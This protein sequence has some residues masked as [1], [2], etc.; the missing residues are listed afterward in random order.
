MK[1]DFKVCTTILSRLPH[2]RCPTNVIRSSYGLPEKLNITS[3]TLICQS[4]RPGKSLY[5]HTQFEAPPLRWLNTAAFWFVSTCKSKFTVT[6]RNLTCRSTSKMR[7][8]WICTSAQRAVVTK[9]FRLIM[10]P[11]QIHAYNFINLINLR[12]YYMHIAPRI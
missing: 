10:A 11:L 4:S 12:L 9:M 7:K 6:A 8:M 2:F 5:P 1:K 3:N